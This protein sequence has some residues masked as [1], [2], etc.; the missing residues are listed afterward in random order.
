MNREA[1]LESRGC[2]SGSAGGSIPVGTGS[3]DQWSVGERLS[4]PGPWEEPE[5]QGGQSAGRS[6]LWKVLEPSENGVTGAPGPWKPSWEGTHW[7]SAKS[8]AK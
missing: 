3:A 7:L 6:E 1:E 8:N 4:H 2:A 5:S